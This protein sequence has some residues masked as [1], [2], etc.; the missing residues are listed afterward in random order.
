MKWRHSDCK[1]TFLFDIISTS[2]CGM[3]PVKPCTERDIKSI[4][5]PCDQQF[6]H[7]FLHDCLSLQKMPYPA[8]IIKNPGHLRIKKII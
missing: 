3:M 6:Y 5:A 2:P 7:T 4:H 1:P 8:F